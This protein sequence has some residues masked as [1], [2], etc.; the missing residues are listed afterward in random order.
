MQLMVTRTV[1]KHGKRGLAGRVDSALNLAFAV[2]ACNAPMNGAIEHKLQP[3][4]GLLPLTPTQMIQLA[5]GM[6]IERERER[7]GTQDEHKMNTHR[8]VGMD[9][10]DCWFLVLL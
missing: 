5:N 2:S 8:G 3:L 1:E 4:P 9:G 7:R 10:C 6:P